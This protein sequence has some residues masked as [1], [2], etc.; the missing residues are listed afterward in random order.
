MPESLS[1]ELDGLDAIAKELRA[2]A[3][4]VAN[5]IAEAEGRLVAV[6]KGIVGHAEVDS[7]R[8]LEAD[9]TAWCVS[10]CH[11]WERDYRGYGLLAVRY[12][13]SGRIAVDVERVWLREAPFHVQAAAL[14][15][16]AGLVSKVAG[17]VRES[18][19]QV[20]LAKIDGV[21]R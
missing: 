19:R 10:L 1:R 21:W 3:D 14:P 18:W 2:D 15:L 6:A 20:Q 7:D 16:L 17:R 13:V 5:A 8:L 9:G 4:G 12:D 11:W